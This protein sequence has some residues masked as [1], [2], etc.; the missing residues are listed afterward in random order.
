[1]ATTEQPVNNALQAKASLSANGR[2]VIPAAVRQALGFSPGETL[3]LDVVDGVLR[4]ESYPSRIRRIQESVR[5][6]IA[7]GRLL[8]EELIAERRDEFRREHEK[9][10]PGDLQA[11]QPPL[12]KAAFPG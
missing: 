1:M 4:I 12:P 5:K 9:D 2:I 10:L 11:D 3:L 8:S 6:H 7:P